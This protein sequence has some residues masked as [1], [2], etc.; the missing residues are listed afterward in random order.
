MENLK[1]NINV[2]SYDY[3]GFLQNVGYTY[4]SIQHTFNIICFQIYSKEIEVLFNERSDFY[5]VS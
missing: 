2:E 3:L 4:R 1:I 5:I